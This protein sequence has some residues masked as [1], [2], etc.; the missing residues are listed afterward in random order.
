[1]V[2]IG[3]GTEANFES[4]LNHKPLDTNEYYGKIVALTGKGEFKKRNNLIL[5]GENE[6]KN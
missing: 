6:I 5:S 3:D 4:R 2:S 1:M